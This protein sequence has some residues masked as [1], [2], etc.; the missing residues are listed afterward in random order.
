MKHYLILLALLPFAA[1][2]QY[3]GEYGTAD[4]T[5][6]QILQR[7]DGYYLSTE[8][9]GNIRMIPE[10]GGRFTLDRVKPV[11]IVDF[12]TNSTGQVTRMLVHQAGRFTWIKDTLSASLL[13]SYHQ[14]I[15]AS[16]HILIHQDGEQLKMETKNL[17]QLKRD[18]YRVLDD[19]Y[20]F[21]RDRNGQ[22][23]R[24]LIDRIGEQVYLPR[25]SQG[26]QPALRMHA[27]D[28]H[29]GF[30]R[31]DTLEGA[32]LPARTCY[33]VLFYDLDV[34]LDPSQRSVQGRN[35]IRFRA[36]RD[37]DS[38]QLDLYANLRIDRI[39]YQGH[40]LTYHREYNAVYVDFPSTVSQ[41]TLG[42]LD[43]QYHGKPILPDPSVLQGGILWL[44][45]TLGNPWAE[46]VCQGTGGSLWWP[47]KDLLSD[48]PDSMRITLTAP[49][50]LTAIS[51]GRLLSTHKMPDGRSRFEW[52]VSYPILNYNVVFYLGDYVHFSDKR[53]DYYCLPYS[54]DKAK[55]VFGGAPAMMDLYERDFGPYPFAGDGFKLVEAPYPMEHQSAVSP[56]PIT[57]LP[58]GTYDQAEVIRTLWHESAHEWWGNSV[59]CADFAD[60]WIHEAFATYTEVL[61][62]TAF[63]GDK[64]AADYLRAQV[65]V[66]K[67]P[68]IG[69]YNVNYFY[70]GDMYSKGC[71]LLN[72]LRH[73]IHN[74]SLFFGAL[75]GIQSQWRF[76][77]I[78]TE[79]LIRS[80]NA[81]TG[82]DYT[83]VFDQY[84][85]HTAL[86]VLEW[87]L[88]DRRFR[89]R[90]Q[91]DVPGFQMPI[92][93]N[94]GPVLLSATSEWQALNLPE[95]ASPEDL[96]VDTDE[97][98]VRTVHN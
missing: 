48:K 53:I 32:P 80:F 3:A 21:Q 44:H 37:F 86:P 22:V 59:S 63:S 85:R 52:Y 90:W 82:K 49:A 71:L 26:L 28:R 97:F 36:V 74:D 75:R 70:L 92:R 24:L 57:P 42:E 7:P 84:L 17:D 98:Y 81:F 76:R 15:D 11:A 79:D 58:G 96:R 94:L 45:D 38:L 31:A 62:Y 77:S 83:C 18:K 1:S 87:S 78:T 93:I 88:Q 30:T 20:T 34:A 10:G 16:L 69:V 55:T 95:S 9:Y 89:Y 40:E 4:T 12:D 67:E 39:L 8:H 19:T 5:L 61:A 54:L 14:D 23:E 73:A 41:G 29:L 51:N 56:G 65:P 66:N 35:R 72:T 43:V 2:A 6:F 27:P 46:S 64:A 60:L 33:D 13:G 25:K 50:G 91:A 47:G 68:I